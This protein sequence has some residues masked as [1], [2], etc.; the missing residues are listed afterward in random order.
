MASSRS[1]SMAKPSACICAAHVGDVLPRPLR[2]RHAVGDGGVLGRQ[3]EGVPAHRLQHV[4][5]LHAHVA[6]QH[7]AD[8]VVAHVAHVQPAR[9]GTET[10]TG[11]RTSRRAASSRAANAR[12]LVPILLRGALHRRGIVALLH[13]AILGQ[14]QREEDLGVLALDEQRHVLTGALAPRPAVPLPCCTRLPLTPRMMSPGSTCASWAGPA[15][16]STSRLPVVPAR[17]FSCGSQRAHGQPERAAAVGLAL[18]GRAAAAAGERRRLL[19]ELL[20]LAR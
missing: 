3:A 11:S 19:L 16:S 2:R 10:S 20:D 4:V 12:L 17:A 14:A 6:R 15:T 13:R 9:R 8:G 18:L 5:A 7:V 1:Q